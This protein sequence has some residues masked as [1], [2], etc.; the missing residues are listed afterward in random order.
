M[1]NKASRIP[2][3]LGAVRAR[4]AGF[5]HQFTDVNFPFDLPAPSA[6]ALLKDLPEHDSEHVPIATG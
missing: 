4:Q 3:D 5:L 6:N 1:G 2:K